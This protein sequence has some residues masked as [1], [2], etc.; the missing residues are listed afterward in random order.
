MLTVYYDGKC[1][2]CRREIRYYRNIAPPEQ[3]DWVDIT[4]QPKRF[5]AN[6]LQLSDGLRELHVQEAEGKIHK[7]ID[8]FIHIWQRL[9][10][11]HLLARVL[12][13]P[14]I[15]WL[16]NRA[17]GVFARWRFARLTHCQLAMEEEAEK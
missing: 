13:L 7:G 3:F 8:A 9:P 16:A 17:Y 4:E 6:G 11:W 2:L 14:G 12:S 5:R 1:G 15:K 10:Y